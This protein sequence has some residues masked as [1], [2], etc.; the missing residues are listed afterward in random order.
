V[1]LDQGLAHAEPGERQQVRVAEAVTDLGGHA[2]GGIRAG[3]VSSRQ[4]PERNQGQQIPLLDAVQPLVVEQPP[5]SG[6]PAAAL[7]LL[8]PEQQEEGQPEPAAG[9]AGDVVQAQPLAMRARPE[10]IALVIPTRQVRGGRQP[11]E[12]LGL[13]PRRV[14]RG[15][16][17]GIRLRPRLRI[18]GLP[19]LL[20]SAG[21]GH[22]LSRGTCHCTA[23]TADRSRRLGNRSPDR[24]AGRWHDDNVPTVGLWEVLAPPEA[25]T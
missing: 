2:A 20:Q 22:T 18:K 9:G 16:E 19:P 3:G 17:L 24:R 1:Q 21:H 13:K 5:G 6:Q 14:V 11:L 15:G 23:T 25:G 7:G 10:I 8:A 4:G 12:I